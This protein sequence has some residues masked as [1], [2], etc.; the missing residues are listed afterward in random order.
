MD[1]VNAALVTGVFGVVVALI[2]KGRKE[3]MRDHQIVVDSISRVDKSLER[4]ESK[5]DTHIRDH[6]LGDV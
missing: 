2:Q 4:I 5:V 3:N 1:A 6:A